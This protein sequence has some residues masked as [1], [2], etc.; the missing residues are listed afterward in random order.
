MDN[1]FFKSENIKKE[2]KILFGFFTNKK[3]FMPRLI[4]IVGILIQLLCAIINKEFSISFNIRDFSLMILTCFLFGT[5]LQI[6]LLYLADLFCKEKTYEQIKK[7][8]NDEYTKI[9]LCNIADILEKNNEISSNTNEIIK[10][11]LNN[12]TE[13]TENTSNEKIKEYISGLK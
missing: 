7:Y 12:N 10:Y 6:P 4:L 1:K 3:F 13:D 11:V 9:D 2:L 5:L 8:N